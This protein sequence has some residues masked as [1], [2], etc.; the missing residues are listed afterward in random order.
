MSTLGGRFTGLIIPNI[1][2][3]FCKPNYNS[4]VATFCSKIVNHESPEVINDANVPLLYV[5]NLVDQI[6]EKIKEPKD[7]LVE[8]RPD[9]EVKVTEVLR[10]LNSFKVS[11]F[12]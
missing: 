2:G 12:R 11:L 7:S 9:V 5:G 10:L 4:F 8:I 6:L 3:P 1:F